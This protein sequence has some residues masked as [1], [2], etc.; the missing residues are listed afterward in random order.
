MKR[1]MNKQDKL[2]ERIKQAAEKQEQQPFDR[3]EEVWKTVSQK[4]NSKKQN[5]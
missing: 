5:A 2:F 3:K 4:L 1:T